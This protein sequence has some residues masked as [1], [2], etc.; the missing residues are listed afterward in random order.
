[1]YFIDEILKVKEAKLH[2]L[3]HMW[4]QKKQK[5]YN[6]HTHIHKIFKSQVYRERELS[7]SGYQGQEVAAT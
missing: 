3:A 6:T 4:N 5:K 7:K 1:M 2:D